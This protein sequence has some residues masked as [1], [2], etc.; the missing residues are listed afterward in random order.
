MI[1]KDLITLYDLICLT[2]LSE[3]QIKRY[4]SKGVLKPTKDLL[5]NYIYFSKET[6]ETFQ[7]YLQEKEKFRETHLRMCEVAR[8]LNVSAA[9]V[10]N[11]VAKGLITPCTEIDNVKYFDKE[12][13]EKLKTELGLDDLENYYNLIETAALLGIPSR[14]LYYIV[15]NNKYKVDRKTHKGNYY[16]SKERIDDL[17][18]KNKQEE[19]V[20]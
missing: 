17:V 15:K 2:G 6:V 7:E 19:Q 4:M 1:R 5:S 8:M 11:Y 10:G 9:T 14:K 16:F 3:S 12:D 20:E 18:E 13:V